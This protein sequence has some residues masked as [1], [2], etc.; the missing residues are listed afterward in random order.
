MIEIDPVN[1]YFRGIN[2]T[3][4]TEAPQSLGTETF[5]RP[6]GMGTSLRT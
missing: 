4:D 6:T 1:F 3:A 5:P 2:N